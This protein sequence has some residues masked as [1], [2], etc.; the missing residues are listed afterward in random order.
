[1]TNAFGWEN[2]CGW[3]YVFIQY[4]FFDMMLH[5]LMTRCARLLVCI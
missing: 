2:Y 5:T 3:R 4:S 1:M